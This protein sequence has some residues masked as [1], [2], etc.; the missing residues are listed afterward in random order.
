[1]SS[2]AARLVSFTPRG[3][4]ALTRAALTAVV[5]VGLR[6][7][8]AVA[9]GAPAIN[10]TTTVGTDPA[11]CA[12]GDSIVVG[13]GTLVVYCHTVENTGGVSLSR[14]DLVDSELGT[15]LNNFPYTLV[16]GASAFLTSSTTVSETTANNAT[17]T[18]YNP[19]PVDVA[20]D[21]DGALV[22]VIPPS[23]DLTTTVGTDP[24]V[25]AS[26][27][28]LDVTAGS[29]VTYCYM[30]TNTGSTVLSRHHLVDSELGAI[31]ND[32]PYTLS[33]SASA[34]LT[35]STTIAATT[36]STSQWT[37]FNP[38]PVDTATDTETLTVTVGG[39][40][41][42]HGFEGGGTAAWD[43]TVP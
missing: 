37:A 32:F 26:G 6:P 9:G 23:V 22:T 14:H 34:F 10:L 42:R 18:A 7:A 43:L 2:M 11:R 3:V 17:W 35:T 20:V 21:S 27:T 41:F 40:L 33:P 38:G 29:Q 12:T 24:S 19:G 5:D 8:P 16:P 1:M 15:V 13:P 36:V 4:P 31:L 28:H 39:L 25:C 30:V